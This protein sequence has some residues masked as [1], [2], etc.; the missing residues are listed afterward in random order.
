MMKKETSLKHRTVNS[1][2]EM[3]DKS[4]AK[5]E[6]D[7]PVTENKDKMDEEEEIEDDKKQIEHWKKY[8]AMS[9]IE[10]YKMEK[11]ARVPSVILTIK[12][13][14]VNLTLQMTPCI[15]GGLKLDEF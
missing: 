1:K 3:E 12:Q 13:Y 8:K 14:Q 9:L 10:K 4:D 15:F 11:S 6:T 2:N 5:T 7:K